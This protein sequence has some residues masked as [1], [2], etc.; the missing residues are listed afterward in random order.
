MEALNEGSIMGIQA[1]MELFPWKEAWRTL[2]QL[3]T[4]AR[5][6]EMGRYRQTWIFRTYKT[7]VRSCKYVKTWVKPAS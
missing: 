3:P 6:L 7:Q 4:K 1:V 5:H 2:V